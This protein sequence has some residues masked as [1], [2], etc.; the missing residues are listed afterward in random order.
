MKISCISVTEFLAE[1]DFPTL[2]Y[3]DRFI[4]FQGDMPSGPNLKIP[5]SSE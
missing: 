5:S 3:F 2:P 1:L 4:R